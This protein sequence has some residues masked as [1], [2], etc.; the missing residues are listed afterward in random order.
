VLKPQLKRVLEEL[1]GRAQ[2]VEIDLEAEAEIA[3]QAG[4][5]GTPTVQ[6]FFRKE[7]KQQFRGVKQRSEF[8]AAIDALLGSAVT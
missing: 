8:R 2:G 7:L 6:L 1:G 4:V 5:T 3:Q